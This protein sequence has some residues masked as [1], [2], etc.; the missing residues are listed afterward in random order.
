MLDEYLNR[1]TEFKGKMRFSKVLLYLYLTTSS[2]QHLTPH[3]LDGEMRF[4]LK[5]DLLYFEFVILSTY[6]SL[7]QKI[8][9]GFHFLLLT[10]IN[11][12]TGLGGGCAT[13]GIFWIMT[14]MK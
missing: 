2:V 1:L 13:T 10:G 9:S 8:E 4:L 6:N 3:T 7:S 12:Q 5:I 11:D 14:W